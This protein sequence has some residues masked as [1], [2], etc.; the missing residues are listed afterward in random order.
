MGSLQNYHDLNAPEA[1]LWN[2]LQKTAITFQNKGQQ[3]S[4]IVR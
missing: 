4:V 1:K 3:V 2:H